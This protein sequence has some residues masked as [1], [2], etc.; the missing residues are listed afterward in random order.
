MR[1]DIQVVI[2]EGSELKALREWTRLL[3]PAS[4]GPANCPEVPMLSK[5]RV[6]YLETDACRLIKHSFSI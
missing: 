5:P 1:A 3:G 6:R 4:K 2:V